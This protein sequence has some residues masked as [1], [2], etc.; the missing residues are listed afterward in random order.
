[1]SAVSWEDVIYQYDGSFDGFLCCVHD[2]Y[3]Y[4]EFP[5]AFEGDEESCVLSLYSVRTVLTQT[6]HARRV[7]RSIVKHSPQAAELLRRAFLT[8][9]PEKEEH[10]YAFVR[11]LFREGP[12][13][14]PGE[15]CIRDI[16]EKQTSFFRKK[17]A[18]KN[19]LNKPAI[20]KDGT[21]I[22]IGINIGSQ[23]FDVPTDRYDFIGLFRT[24]FLYME[25]KELP[26]EETQFEA[27]RQ[28]VQKAKGH[29]ITLRTLDIGGD[30]TLPYMELPKEDNPFLGKRA[31]RLCF[32]EKE[33]FLTQLRAALRAS[34]YGPLQI[35][36]PMVGSLEDIRKAKEY[37]NLA[38]EQL[39]E[40]KQQF[41]EQI[42]IGIMIEIPAIAL[43]ADLAAEEVDFASI[44]SNDLTQ[45][46]SAAD[47]MNPEVAAYYKSDS[48]AMLR[49]LRFV[50]QEF[51]KRGKEI[52][53]CGEMAGNPETAQLLVGLGARKLSMSSGNIAGV[54]AKLAECT[55]QE[56]TALAEKKL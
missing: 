27:Y 38:K 24:E 35:M 46:L 18:E 5:I 19:F 29:P 51:S 30:K 17:E 52:S 45:Y 21:E 7:Y 44:G 22:K 10:L 54:K 9:M 33:L 32:A 40:R 53:V 1:M 56:L 25:G 12:A 41:D 43:I 20:M 15:E 4:K 2:S 36:F 34:A 50:F 11:K 28:V 8:C 23:E 3:I 14:T 55:L 26:G 31:I 13:V 37:L 6:E 16:R 48:T 42:R 39:K 49:L 47:R